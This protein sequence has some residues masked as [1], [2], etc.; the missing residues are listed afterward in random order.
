MSNFGQRG[1]LEVYDTKIEGEVIINDE[2]F[3]KNVMSRD[4]AN[5]LDLQLVG[6][7]LT[8]INSGNLILKQ[9]TS[10]RKLNLSSNKLKVIQNLDDG[11][12]QLK[13]LDLG[14][15]EI[16]KIQNLNFPQLEILCLNNNQIKRIEN[17]K[18]LKKLQKLDLSANMITEPSLQGGAQQMLELK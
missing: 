1:H 15:N 13:E 6:V 11:C 9:L 2:V 10:L 12:R 5:I 3:F 18:S 4:Y 8:L 7:G 14:Y 16:D 17:L